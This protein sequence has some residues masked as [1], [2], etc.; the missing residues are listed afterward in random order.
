MLKSK[1]CDKEEEQFV[2]LIKNEIEKEVGEKH[3][4]ITKDISILRD[5]L[6]KNFAAK[7][8]IAESKSDMIKCMFIFVFS[9]S[10]LTIVSI[11]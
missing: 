2:A 3:W 6:Y 9:S 5:V 10:L 7:A 11:L 1:F 4:I 8:D